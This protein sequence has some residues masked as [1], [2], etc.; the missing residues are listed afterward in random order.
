MG[1]GTWLKMRKD[2]MWQRG[3]AT[4][5]W[6][7]SAYRVCRYSTVSPFGTGNHFDTGPRYRQATVICTVR[8]RHYPHFVPLTGYYQLVGDIHFRAPR[9]FWSPTISA[10]SW[11][12]PLYRSLSKSQPSTRRIPP[13]Y[14]VSLGMY[15]QLH[16]QKFQICT[17][18]LDLLYY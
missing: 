2:S 12:L 7:R 1:G 11:A 9:W 10:L 8:R 3:W 4:K 5:S 6:R 16:H 15:P 18:L 17:R 14:L 13:G